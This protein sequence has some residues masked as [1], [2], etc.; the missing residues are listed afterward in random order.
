MGNFPPDNVKIGASMVRNAMSGEPNAGEMTERDRNS[1]G[2]RINRRTIL[3]GIGASAGAI[4]GLTGV[5]AAKSKPSKKQQE[6]LR[7]LV[8]RYDSQG[9]ALKAVEEYGSGLLNEINNMSSVSDQSISFDNTR[10]VKEEEINGATNGISV[11]AYEM[12]GVN[13]ARITAVMQNSM[14]RIELFVHPQADTHYMAMKPLDMTSSSTDIVVMDKSD[15]GITTQACRAGNN[16]V[17]MHAADYGCCGTGLGCI[18]T[19]FARMV[20]DSG[21]CYAGTRIGC[22][23][24]PDKC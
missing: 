14:N 3:K 22:C 19:K 18:Y 1:N 6:D 2:S 17:C 7:E 10:L 9:A 23:G 11:S 20:C 21:G 12:D 8:H 4:S 13:T 24:S 16:P 15:D 5:A